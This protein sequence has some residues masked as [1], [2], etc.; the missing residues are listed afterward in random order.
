MRQEGERYYRLLME[1]AQIGYVHARSWQDNRGDWRFE[2]LTHFSLNREAPVS[3]SDRL[4]F[5]AGPP[6]S[7]SAAEHWNRR[8]GAAP[9][10][11]ILQS[12]GATTTTTPPTCPCRTT[13]RRC[14]NPC[15]GTTRLHSGW[16]KLITQQIS[17][18]EGLNNSI[19]RH[20]RRLL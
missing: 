20:W 12:D 1:G 3:I 14:C 13:K 8:G 19:E 15:K 4:V 6:Y 17:K 2:T 5:Q 16:M 10:G 18:K 7:L 9:E 11:V